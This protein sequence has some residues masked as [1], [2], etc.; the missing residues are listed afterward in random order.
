V[1]YYLLARR[2]VGVSSL[3]RPEAIGLSIGLQSVTV[4]TSSNAFASALEL[5]I[6]PAPVESIAPVSV[7]VAPIELILGPQPASV[8]TGATVLAAPVE[9]ILGTEPTS[10]ATQTIVS[11]DSMGLTL[12]PLG[13]R[14]G[15]FATV[16]PASLEI[17]LSSGVPVVSTVAHTTVVSTALEIILG[18]SP[19]SVIGI[20]GRPVVPENV[21]P[22]REVKRFVREEFRDDIRKL[23]TTNALGPRMRD[24]IE[25]LMRMKNL[26]PDLRKE[27]AKLSKTS[28]IGPD[29][30]KEIA[31][32]MRGRAE[33][34]KKFNEDLGNK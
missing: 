11:L 14:A 24:E 13:V 12:E 25:T 18:L 1:S 31:I 9:L 23:M 3:V 7:F 10:V 27:L 29:L 20:D 19:T 33:L 6:G 22:L 32:L 26:G 4:S 30:R 21:V 5:V 34:A 16:F 17:L 28:T 15:Q 8:S 2:G